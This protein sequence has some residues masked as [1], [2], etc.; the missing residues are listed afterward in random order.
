MFERLKK[1][2]TEAVFAP[3]DGH[4]VALPDVTD[5]VFAQKM[6]GE[7]FGIQPTSAEIYAPIQG[8]V[9]TIFQT[10][11]AIGLTGNSGSEVLI[12]IG[13]DTVELNGEPF[14]VHVKEGQSVDE[15]TLLVTAD[16]EKVRAAGKAEVVLTLFTNGGESF[17]SLNKNQVK[18]Q[19][20]LR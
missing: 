7:G 11:H 12:H 9:T 15:T 8:T 5:P 17:D 18:H 20:T 3:V 10:K 13:L 14:E 1:K 6:M 4:F 2:K 19:E 16:F